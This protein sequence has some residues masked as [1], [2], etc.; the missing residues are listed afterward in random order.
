LPEAL[1]E[2]ELFGHTRG[3]FTGATAPRRGLFLE[4]DGG[5]LFL[6]EIGD[7][8]PALQAKLLRAIDEGEVRAVGADTSR[9]VDVRLVAATHQDLEK[10]VKA[11]QFRADLFYRLNVVSLQVPSLRERPEDIPLLIERFLVRARERNPGAP[12]AKLTPALVARLA[13][14]AW[15]GNVRELENVVERLV[16]LTNREIADVADL[17]RHAA[18]V[19]AEP[20]PL[21][22]AQEKIMPL[23]QLED[24]YIAWVLARCGGNKTR[25]A[26]LLE[27]DVSTIYRRE[28]Q[29]LR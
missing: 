6:D 17:E 29:T 22:A 4:A 10:R 2:S 23:R 21:A 1:L 18:Q 5:T 20:S 28:R 25:A 7:M 9:S 24:E 11:G 3:A 27:I 16:I 8:A 14:S 15:P 19:A 26:E 13:A 12:V